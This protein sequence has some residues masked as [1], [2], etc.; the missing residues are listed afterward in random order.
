[1]RAL[2]LGVLT[3]FS[4][5]SA[6]AAAT[7]EVSSD[8]GWCVIYIDGREAGEI[9]LNE[10]HVTIRDIPPGEHFFKIT[11]AFDKVWFD[12]VLKF[13]ETDV[14]R[15]KAEPTGLTVIN[16]TPASPFAVD[17]APPARPA[18]VR[19]DYVP[20][21]SVPT[22]LYVNSTPAALPF[23]INGQDKGTTPALITDLAPGKHIITVGGASEEVQL[24]TATLTKVEFVVT[25]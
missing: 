10:H 23:Q 15:V 19:V 22:M 1:M 14:L 21:K 17:V 3:V 13:G 2:K 25:P 20:Y 6:A 16:Q 5:A 4:L 18:K 8:E 9:P 7:L 24:T 12:G 11:D